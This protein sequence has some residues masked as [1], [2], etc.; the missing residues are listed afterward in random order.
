MSTWAVVVAA[1]SGE[2][3]GRPKQYEHL[4]GRRV[5]DWSLDAAR[6]ACD[7]VVVVV[8]PAFALEPEARADV[9]VAGGAT[10]AESVRRGLTAVPPDATVVVV[11]DAARPLAGAGA[12]A[13]VLDAVRGGADG[14]VCAVPVS[15]TVKRVQAGRV[16]ETVERAGLW[17]IQTPQ[18]F[19]AAVLRSAHA[20]AAEATDDASLVEVAG[21]TVV[22]VEGDPRNIK[23]TGPDDLVVAEALLATLR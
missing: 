21:G 8:G 10:R 14:A 17:S 12:F 15:D 11:H 18:A 2:R 16:V 19:A 4:G 7:G 20:G 22:V 23:L 5:L 13:A 6:A 9:V 3:F 1:G